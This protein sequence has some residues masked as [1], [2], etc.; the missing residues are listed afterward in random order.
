MKI[1]REATFSNLTDHNMFTFTREF[2]PS[3]RTTKLSSSPTPTPPQSERE[4]ATPPKAVP[5][6]LMFGRAQHR[7][8]RSI[9]LMSMSVV[10]IAE[11]C[12]LYFTEKNTST[13]TI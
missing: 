8:A 2:P 4:T 9:L 13:L 1:N 12:R 5:L 7:H 6:F 3:S 11:V 10:Q